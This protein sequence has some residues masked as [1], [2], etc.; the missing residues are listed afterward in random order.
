MFS[1]YGALSNEQLLFAYGYAILDN[2][3]DSLP[4]KLRIPSTVFAT[5]NVFALK[6]GGWDGVP[7][8]SYSLLPWCINSPDIVVL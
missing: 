5:G 7:R 1:N 2:Q 4:M 3:N 6:S 8:V